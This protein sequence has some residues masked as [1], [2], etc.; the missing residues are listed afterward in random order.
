MTTHPAYRSSPATLRRL[1]RHP[2]FFQPRGAREDVIGRLTLANVGLAATAL[3]ARRFGS[4]RMDALDACA[5]EAG[6]RL[7]LRAW[8]AWPEDERAA[9]IRW[10]PVVLALPGLERWSG[11][12]RRALAHVIR[13][14]GSR[15]ESDFV[16]AFDAHTRLRR[17]LERLAR[18]ADP[19]RPASRA[20][21]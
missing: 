11:A 19:D 13:L 15:R 1:A 18:E 21:P 17:S 10:A 9:W 5:R 20:R 4:D 6:A 14:K 7:G 3:L 16:R 12:E 2:L 8:R